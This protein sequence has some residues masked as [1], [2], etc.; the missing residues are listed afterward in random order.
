MMKDLVVEAAYVGNRGV[1]FQNNALVNYN[2][3]DPVYLNS[4]FSRLGLNTT[5][6]ADRSLLTGT[7]TSAAAVSKGF[8]KPYANFPD[9]GT[10]IQTLK[11]YPQYNGIGATWAPLGNTWYDAL[12]VKVTKRYAHGLDATVSYAYS[13]NLTNI[14]S[15]LGNVFDRATFKGLSPD[16]RPHILTM[17][18][19]YEVPAYGFAKKSRVARA[20]LAGWTIGAGMQYQS[21]ALLAAPG[22]N[23]S[24]GTYY[25][26]QSSRWFRVPGAP[27]YSKDL[28]CG[29]L[30]PDV[31]TVLNPAAW[32]DA[33]LGAFGAQQTYFSD[34]RGQRRPSESL[35]FGKRFAFGE[36]SRKALAIRVEFF[37]V[38]NRMV[39]L[40]DPST[41]NPQ[42]APTR[43]SQNVLTGGFGFV[44]FNAID[45]N[46]Q[47]NAYP[48]PRT[49]QF[50]AR[51]EF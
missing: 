34:F 10:V 37:N 46:N 48:A 39:S 32:T 16:D 40:P 11:P 21:G 24:I 18:V 28:N 36:R 29:C 42:T 4:V 13:K 3:I 17:S 25:P 20:A 51:F 30:K 31:E 19:R 8:S 45:S 12:Q 43:N 5:V 27:L 7:I 22:S 14:G 1:W 6:A 38:L 26:G 41:A 50:V 23:N 35:A 15:A 9:N 44:N 47:N 33:P 49:G 2:A